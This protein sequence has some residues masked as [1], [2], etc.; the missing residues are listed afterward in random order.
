M[1]SPLGPPLGPAFPLPRRVR[2]F[3]ELTP[4]G[5][6]TSISRSSLTRPSPW[7]LAHASS[8]I[9]PS[10]PHARHGATD[11]NWP[12]TD[13]WTC[14]SSPDPP[15]FRHGT[16]LKPGAAP[17][18]PQEP[19]G[20]R[21]ATLIF[22]VTP[23]ATSFRVRRS[24]TRRVWPFPASF[25]PG[26]APRPPKISSNPARPPKSLMKTSMASAK[27]NP[28]KPGDPGPPLRPC[29]PYR[30]YLA[31]FSESRRAS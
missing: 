31:R 24:R 8:I 13:R 15:Q 11:T 27:S 14:R 20:S 21:R 7:Q 23:V 12:K 28:P 6:S 3:S 19:H 10:P 4:E 17:D 18:P 16:G 1:I 5:T 2:K 22:F 30:S 25:R 29:S 26:L 9:L